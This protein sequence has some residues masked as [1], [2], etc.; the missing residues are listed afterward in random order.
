MPFAES[1][2]IS[3]MPPAKVCG[4]NEDHG[5]DAGF[6]TGD[7][8]V[9]QALSKLDELDERDLDEHADVYSDIHRSLG[10]VLDGGSESSSD[11]A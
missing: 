10:S 8:A 7:A 3:T 1:R 2:Q 4:V 5:A 11:S 9:D 6:S